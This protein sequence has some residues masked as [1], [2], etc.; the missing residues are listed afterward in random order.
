MQGKDCSYCGGRDTPG[1]AVLEF[2]RWDAKR[3]ALVILLGEMDN[4][5]EFVELMLVSRESWIRIS[6]FIR[7]VISDEMRE[8]RDRTSK[9]PS[10]S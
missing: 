5:A 6:T 9:N 8:S 1:H 4:A 2:G 10:L 3:R 7:K